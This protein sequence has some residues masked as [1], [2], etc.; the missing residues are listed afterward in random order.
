MPASGDLNFMKKRSLFARVF[1]GI[2]SGI[3]GFRKVLH[4]LLLL[5]LFVIFFG[6]LSGTAPLLPE[7]AALLI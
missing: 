7:R 4:L 1:S 6:A 2:W 5:F 3:D